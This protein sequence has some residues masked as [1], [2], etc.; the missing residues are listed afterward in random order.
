[1]S[2]TRDVLSSGGG[3]T[4]G[5]GS[6]ISS[7]A[8]VRHRFS[9]LQLDEGEDYVSDFVGMCKA[10]QGAFPGVRA[11]EHTPHKLRGRIRLMSGSLLFDPDDLAAP[12]LKFP[13]AAV[14]R[15]DALGGVHAAF[16]LVCSRCLCRQTPHEKWKSSTTSTHPTLA[17]VALH[18]YARDTTDGRNVRPCSPCCYLTFV[19]CRI[20]P[21][22]P[23]VALRIPRSYPT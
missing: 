11:G 6:S 4:R 7:P 9:L 2:A 8:S 14:S 21:L 13:L 17:S 5:G 10:P 20:P 15:L 18:P 23:V 19:P 22:P 1:M 3:A 12:M 16:E